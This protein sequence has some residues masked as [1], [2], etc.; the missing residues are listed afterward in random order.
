MLLHG[1]PVRLKRF[2]YFQF[3]IR[4]PNSSVRIDLQQVL[5]DQPNLL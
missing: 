2:G 1:F 5:F 4:F 3:D